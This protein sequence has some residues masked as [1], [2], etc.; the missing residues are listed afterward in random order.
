MT[1]PSYVSPNADIVAELLRAAGIAIRPADIDIREREDRFAALLPGDHVAWF[2]TGPTGARRLASEARVLDLIARHCGFAAPRVLEAHAAW[3]LRRLVPGAVDP[4]AAYRRVVADPAYAASIGSTIGA[5]L[6]DQHLSI[7]AAELAWLPRRSS[8]PYPLV[9][10]A[11]NLPQVIGDD[12]LIEQALATIARYDQVQS[13]TIDRVLTHGDLGLHNL[14]FAADGSIAGIFDYDDAAFSDRHDDFEFLL[15][16]TTG[17]A[18]LGAAIVGYEAAGGAP[19]DRAMV[20]LFNAA[21]AI[22]FLADRLG[23]GPDDKPAGRTLAED[24]KWTT[25]AMARL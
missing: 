6:A 12:L 23:S 17:D 18:M 13:A 24:L 3:Q 19:I 21:N 8:W 16:D 11:A 2:A 5:M 10:I 1:A 9:T 20:A 7:P 14:A 15:F 22:G 4:W 25:Q